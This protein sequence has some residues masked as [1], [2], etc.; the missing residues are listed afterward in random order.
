M[1]EDPF[2]KTYWETLKEI[3]CSNCGAELT[4]EPGTEHLKC[5]YCGTTNLIPEEHEV[6]LVEETPLVEY[7]QNKLNQPEEKMEVFT[8]VCQN[9]HAQTTFEPN[10]SS[11]F[12]PFCDTPLIVENSSTHKIDKPSYL[13]PFYL[14]EKKARNSYKMWLSKLFWAPNDLKKYA[15]SD[16]F[17]GLYLP[18]YTFDCHTS[19]DYRGERGDNYHDR[20]TVMVNQNGRMVPQTRT[21]TKTRWRSASGRVKNFF[22]DVLVVGSRN[23]DV[24]KLQKI[25]TWDLQQLTNYNEKYLSGFKTEIFEVQLEEGYERAKQ[26][27]QTQI[28]YTIRRDIGGDH[29]RIH[30]ANTQYT[31]ATFK[32]ILLPIWMSSYRYRGKIYQIMVNARTG[33]VSG[34]SP[35]SKW[36]V[37]IAVILGIIAIVAIFYAT[38]Q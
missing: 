38:R 8:V 15:E 11:D 20:Q 9:C 13:L 34:T 30:S 3:E 22:D 33:R 36:K 27:M 1:S 23:V 4:Y 25:N 37:A 14:S 29:Q 16:H 31:G 10:I 35:V 17:Q 28:N 24:E 26:K 7:L 19:T 12:C 32:E 21:V 6:T 5:K 18:Y 2:D